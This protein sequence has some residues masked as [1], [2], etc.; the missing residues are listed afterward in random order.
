VKTVSQDALLKTLQRYYAAFNAGDDEAMLELVTEDVAHDINQGPREIG[1]T[2]F[3]AFLQRMRHSYREEL[4]DLKFYL[5]PEGLG[6]AAEYVVHGTYLKADVGLP[7]ARGQS[8]VLPGGAFFGFEGAKI[9]RV[10]NYYNL[11]EWLLQVR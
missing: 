11:E 10:T 1:K 9:C 5:N 8:Y 6:G 3:R 2:S 7:L 4:R